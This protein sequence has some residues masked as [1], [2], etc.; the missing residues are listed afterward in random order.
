MDDFLSTSRHR[1]SSH[2]ILARQ[3]LD[4]A[5]IKYALGANAGLFLWIDLRP[6]LNTTEETEGQDP[7]AA[8]DELT[9]R[10][11]GNGVYITNGKELSASE[12]GWYRLIFSQE[13]P[14]VREG[15][16]RITETIGGGKA[17]DTAGET[18]A[19]SQA[20]GESL[21][22]GDLKQNLPATVPGV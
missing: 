4:D 3:L 16:K 21:E 6:H 11:I 7:F 2:N 12:P 14:H 22:V 5:G 10:L 8:E 17:T 9:G 19:A 13:E 1:L 18:P 15:I 20:G